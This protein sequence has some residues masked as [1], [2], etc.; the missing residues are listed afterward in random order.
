VSGDVRAG[1]VQIVGISPHCPVY[2]N[3]DRKSAIGHG[4][5]L[6]SLNERCRVVVNEPVIR[7]GL[8]SPNHVHLDMLEPPVTFRAAFCARYRC[9]DR[10]F[11]RTFF[12]RAVYRHALIPAAIIRWCHPRFFRTDADL[13]QWVGAAINLPEVRHE[14]ADFEYRNRVSPHWLRTGFLVQLSP[15]RVKALARAC[16]QA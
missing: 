9:A 10:D 7:L 15:S 12:R 11:E 14:L 4:C 13:I 3:L 1:E 2:R 16:L 5:A 6:A 8:A